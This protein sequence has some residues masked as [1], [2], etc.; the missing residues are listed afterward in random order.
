MIGIIQSLTFMYVALDLINTVKFKN[1]D[2][3]IW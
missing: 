3:Q 1:P 2:S